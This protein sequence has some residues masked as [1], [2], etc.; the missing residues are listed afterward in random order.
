MSIPVVKPNERGYNHGWVFRN[1][2]QTC[3][4]YKGRE[5]GRIFINLV[6]IL[7]LVLA[8]IPAVEAAQARD[9]CVGPTYSKYT[10]RAYYVESGE[11][12]DSIM[13]V[14]VLVIHTDSHGD[15]VEIADEIMDEFEEIGASFNS[16]EA[17]RL[18]HPILASTPIVIEDGFQFSLI[19]FVG[20]NFVSQWMVFGEDT[21]FLDP[22]HI[23][24]LGSVNPARPAE[25]LGLPNTDFMPNGFVLVA[26]EFSLSG[27]PS[28]AASKSAPE[29]S[30]TRTP[31]V[32]SSSGSPNSSDNQTRNDSV[33]GYVEILSV[34]S[35]DAGIGDGSKYVYV[36]IQNTADHSLAYVHIDLV[37][38]DSNSRVVATGIAN[39]AGLAPGDSAVLTGIIMDANGCI[40]V[41]AKVNP[42][43]S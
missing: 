33:S 2:E 43:T 30:I 18:P 41:E 10:C 16:Y 36:E 11:F 15:S 32:S 26:E 27:P 28:T 20:E 22:A 14:Q 8:T 13:G 7:G 9:E 23:A 19:L 5:V 4:L 21:W 29:S 34:S 38:R 31:R 1:N 39:I 42:L 24:H 37:C 3:L 40:G 12:R 25:L 6:L 17:K 35:K